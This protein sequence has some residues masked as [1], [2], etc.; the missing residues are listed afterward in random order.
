MVLEDIG[1]QS[2]HQSVA[3]YYS[4]VFEV[5]QKGCPIFEKY[6]GKKLTRN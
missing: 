3:L 5:A 1:F 6:I 4:R 2:E